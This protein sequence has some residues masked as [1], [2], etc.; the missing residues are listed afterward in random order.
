[1]QKKYCEE[2]EA[3]NIAGALPSSWSCYEHFHSIL[4]GTKKINGAIG[5]IDEGVQ[6]SQPQVENLDDLFETM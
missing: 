3:C 4:G 2:H 5:S 1:M 6:L